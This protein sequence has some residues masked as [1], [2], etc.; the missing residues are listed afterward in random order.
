MRRSRRRND[1]FSGDGVYSQRKINF[2]RPGI[3]DAQRFGR[4]RKA[5]GVNLDDVFAGREPFKTKRALLVGFGRNLLTIIA[6]VKLHGGADDSRSLRIGN[7][8]R[9]VCRV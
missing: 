7:A 1:D 5:F 4:R 3:F 6:F 2:R 8:G 9:N